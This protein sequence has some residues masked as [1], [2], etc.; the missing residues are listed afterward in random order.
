VSV[1]PEGRRAPTEDE[2][3]EPCAVPGC[4]AP[5]ARSLARVEARKVFANLSDSGRRAPLCRDHYKEW[6]KST[7]TARKLDRLT[8]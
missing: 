7:K 4:G 6:K 3:P 1:P 2:A 5:S 8:W